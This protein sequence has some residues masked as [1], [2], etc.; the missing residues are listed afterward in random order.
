MAFLR[1]FSWQLPALS[2]RFHC[3]HRVITARA[4]AAFGLHSLFL[5]LSKA[6]DLVYHNIF[7]QKLSLSGLQILLQIGLTHIL[8]I[9][10]KTLILGEQSKPLD[11]TAGAPQGSVIGPILF[12]IYINDLPLTLSNSIADKFADD[13]TLSVR[14]KYL[15]EVVTTLSYDLSQIDT[16]CEQNRMCI[17]Q[18]K[19]KDLFIISKGNSSRVVNAQPQIHLN[20]S[21]IEAWSTHTHNGI[22]KC[23]SYIYLLS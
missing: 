21:S 18:Q 12:L 20:D 17:T 16:W 2:R 15:D 6:F 3:V 23:N 7:I 1:R 5:D 8:T 10:L 22:E 13:T 9:E 4:L 19:S 11:V 14:S